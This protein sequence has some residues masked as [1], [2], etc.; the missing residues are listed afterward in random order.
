MRLGPRRAGYRHR[1]RVSRRLIQSDL[2]AE[3]DRSVIAA[4]LALCDFR[5]DVVLRP[6]AP[7]IFTTRRPVAID[8]DERIERQNS[9]AC[10]A[11]KSRGVIAADAEVVCVDRWCLKEKNSSVW[12]NVTPSAG[13][14]SSIMCRPDSQ[15][16]SG[17]F[18]D[19]AVASIRVLTRR[20]RSGC[21]HGTITSMPNGLRVRFPGLST[22]A[23]KWR[24][25]ASPAISG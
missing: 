5:L 25:P 7:P 9:L 4:V 13:A 16:G 14:R 20:T 17:S 1:G 12:A 21:D 11:E 19:C 18:P 24:A 8:R 22:R 6:R 23:S 2:R 3:R 10:T 15:L